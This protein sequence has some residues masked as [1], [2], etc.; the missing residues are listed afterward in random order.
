MVIA[1]I[2]WRR[3]DSPGHDSCC[4]H[5]TGDGWRLEGTAV[6]MHAGAAARLTYD[7]ACDAAW[8]T[9][10][11]VVEGWIGCQLVSFRIARTPDGEWICNNRRVPGLEGCLDLDFG[12]TPATNTA[13]LRRLALIEGQSANVPAAWLDAG[14]GTLDLLPQRYERRSATSCWYEAP[15]FGYA[16]LL[17][18][19]AV[20]FVVRYPGLWVAEI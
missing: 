17:E 3:I 20:G 18:V 7:L 14:A 4:L 2:L 15:R 1:S 8:R 10:H 11:G 9:Q 16:A 12:F 5:D 6:F 19:S 13:Q